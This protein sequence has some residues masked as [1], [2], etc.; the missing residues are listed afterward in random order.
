MIERQ[1]FI[2]AAPYPLLCLEVGSGV[3]F[4]PFKIAIPYIPN[5]LEENDFCLAVTERIHDSCGNKLRCKG[6]ARITGRYSSIS[7]SII[8]F[9]VSGGSLVCLSG[10]CPLGDSSGGSGEREPRVP[11]PVSPYV[12]E[13][14]SIAI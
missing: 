2:E 14:L 11:L 4:Y 7:I 8:G 12:P 5:E 1:M 6:S 9:V 10:Q 3:N 13:R